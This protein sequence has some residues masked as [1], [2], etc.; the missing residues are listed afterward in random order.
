MSLDRN[1][2]SGIKQTMTSPKVVTNFP[3]IQRLES[4]ID[5]PY[6]FAHL[7]PYRTGA[8]LQEYGHLHRWDDRL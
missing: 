5:M 8:Q 7:A 6:A 2:A 4:S 1:K 3:G